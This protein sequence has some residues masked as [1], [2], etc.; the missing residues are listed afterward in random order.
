MT[1][2]GGNN[3]C[4]GCAVLAPSGSF[5][6]LLAPSG[7]FWLLVLRA[8]WVERNAD[9]WE[10]SNNVACRAVE[11]I[12]SVGSVKLVELVEL[13]GHTTWSGH[14]QYV[15]VGGLYR[16]QYELLKCVGVCKERISLDC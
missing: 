14:V 3:D 11:S 2:E 4:R 13:V 6:L 15:M 5:W 7:S 9:G 10:R 1:S 8:K 16:L 12:E